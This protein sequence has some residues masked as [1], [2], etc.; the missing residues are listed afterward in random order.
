MTKIQG[1]AQILG[2]FPG[3]TRTRSTRPLS[4]EEMRLVER[5]RELSESDRIA[6]RYLMDAM[7]RVSRF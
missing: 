4:L 6:M 3:L 5:Y 2:I 7:G 1:I